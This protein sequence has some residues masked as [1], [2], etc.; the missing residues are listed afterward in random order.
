MKKLNVGI[1][2]LG[3]G[4]RHLEAY[5]QHARCGSIT[6]CDFDSKKV[7]RIQ[8][9]YP[10]VKVAR[11]AN[12]ILTDPNIQAVS[13]ASYD[14]YHYA[15]VCQ[16]IKNNKHVFVEKPICLHPRDAKTIKKLLNARPHLKIFSN[17]I[18]RKSPRFQLLKTMIRAGKLGTI[19]HMEGDYNYGRLHK[20]TEGWR[21]KIDFY[22]VVYGGGIHVI[23]LMLWLTG[24]QVVEVSACGN[25]ISSRGTRFRYNDMVT[26]LL[27]FKSTMTAKV[28]ANYS[29]VQP[30]FHGFTVY[31]TKGTFI[32]GPRCVLLY[33]SRNPLVKPKKIVEPYPGVHKGALIREFV[34]AIV[35]GTDPEVTQKEIF[36]VMDVC[37]AI[38]KAV[39][40]NGV[41]VAQ[42]PVR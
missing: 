8:K 32:N 13:I 16:A 30:H 37:F 26:G 2:G 6:V 12:K 18:L 17:L 29:C 14:N 27:T 35:R 42:H 11:D 25:N 15:Q 38:E 41:R 36:Q 5:A 40:R 33:T 31:G 7:K 21:G 23:D 9:K 34:D 24:D 19:Y 1:I 20:I 3:V 22:S 39:K 10:A 4:E 28:S